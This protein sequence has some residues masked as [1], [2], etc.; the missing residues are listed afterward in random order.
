M[1]L[2]MTYGPMDGYLCEFQPKRIPKK[3]QFCHSGKGFDRFFTTYDFDPKAKRFYYSGWSLEDLKVPV[4][5]DCIT[6]PYLEV[7]GE[8]R[9]WSV[10]RTVTEVRGE[11]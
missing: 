3:V 6:R 11:Q 8:S 5:D 9:F 7:A 1:Q 2:E 4:R 10:W